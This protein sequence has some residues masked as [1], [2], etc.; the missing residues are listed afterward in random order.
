MLFGF[1][2]RSDGLSCVLPCLLML[3]SRGVSSQPPASGVA[4][5]TPQQ[6]QQAH[7]Y[8]DQFRGAWGAVVPHRVPPMAIPEAYTRPSKK[9]GQSSDN[10]SVWPQ[11][12]YDFCY[13]FPMAWECRGFRRHLY[14]PPFYPPPRLE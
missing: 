8:G 7:R 9:P 4:P 12:Y 1:P 2:K 13:R 6:L 10:T 5:P 11:P 3:V 14:Y